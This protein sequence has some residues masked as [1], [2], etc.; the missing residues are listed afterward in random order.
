M[1][2][3]II[4]LFAFALFTFVPEGMAQTGRLENKEQRKTERAERKREKEKELK[5]RHEVLKDLVQ[6]Q[7]FVL[8][9]ST[10][11]GRYMHP[12]QVQPNTNFVKVDGERV[13]VQTSNN[14]SFGYNGL[15]GITLHGIISDYKVI[16]KKGNG[17]SVLI[18]F[19]NPAIGYSTL[20]LDLSTGGAARALFI[21]NWGRRITFQGQLDGLESTRVFEG[22]PII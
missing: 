15:G 21:D 2:L 18:N 22:T 6:E 16:S 11:F 3:Y 20:N 1:N 8:E 9:A 17:V 12:Y 14:H 7:K 4:I 10:I 5:R 19:T 13:T